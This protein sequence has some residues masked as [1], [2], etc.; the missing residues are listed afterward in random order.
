MT[1]LSPARVLIATTSHGEI[2]DTGRATGAYVPE[3][4]HAWHVFRVAGYEVD[5]VSVRGGRPPLE[6]ADRTDPV[7]AA[8]LDDP[9]AAAQLDATLRPDQVEPHAYAAVLVAGGHGAVW[10]LPEDPPL[11]T[12]LRD[13]WENGGVVAA[14]CHGPAALVNVVL[15]D[16]THLVAGRRVSGFTNDEEAA[17]GMTDLVPFLLA[18]ALTERGAEFVSA[19]PF[20]PFVA[21]DGRL[22]T[23]QNPPSATGVAEATVAALARLPRRAGGGLSAD[24]PVVGARA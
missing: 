6:A 11:A 2:G 19:P 24:G 14:V 1:G 12:L 5:L 8:F 9:S 21:V 16:G 4:A 7:Q 17:V 13:V 15:T 22:V 18:D 3:V 20:L 10:D 23:G